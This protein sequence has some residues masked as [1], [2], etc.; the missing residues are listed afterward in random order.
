M[1]ENSQNHKIDRGNKPRQV[2]DPLGSATFHTPPPPP[3]FFKENLTLMKRG[4][5]KSPKES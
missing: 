2:L 1:G 5:E 3:P 4:G